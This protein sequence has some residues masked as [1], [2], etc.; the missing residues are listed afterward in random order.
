MN[1]HFRIPPEHQAFWDEVKIA[2]APYAIALGFGIVM[3]AGSIWAVI[4]FT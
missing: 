1:R 4:Y 3:I 2:M